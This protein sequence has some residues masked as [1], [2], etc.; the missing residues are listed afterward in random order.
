MPPPRE[1]GL[2]RP[3][4]QRVDRDVTVQIGEALAVGVAIY[5]EAGLDRSRY[6]VDASHVEVPEVAMHGRRPRP[7][8]AHD[9]IALTNDRVHVPTGERPVRFLRCRRHL[10]RMPPAHS[11]NFPTSRREPSPKRCHRGG[12]VAAGAVELPARP[13]GTTAGRRWSGRRCGC[14]TTATGRARPLSVV[15]DMRSWL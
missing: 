4:R 13:T 12:D 11:Q 6:P 14:R 2:P 10:L 9:R 7:S 15:F 1:P 5:A 8:V 3:S